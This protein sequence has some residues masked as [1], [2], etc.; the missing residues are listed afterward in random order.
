MKLS[1]KFFKNLLIASIVSVT[2]IITV[3]AILGAALE[4]SV[5][6]LAFFI[7]CLLS[8]GSLA[9]FLFGP[10]NW[11]QFAK[12]ALIVLAIIGGIA[13]LIFTIWLFYA[14]TQGAFTF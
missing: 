2:I 5:P 9:V 4:D 1:N 8:V 7:F 14:G 12:K 11:K 3:M 10:T 13:C 6:N